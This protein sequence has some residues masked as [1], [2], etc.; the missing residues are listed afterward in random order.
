MSRDI[1]ESVRVDEVELAYRVVGDGIGKY[2]QRRPTLI[3]SAHRR[4][5]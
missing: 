2:G 3:M 5:G 4:C 1:V